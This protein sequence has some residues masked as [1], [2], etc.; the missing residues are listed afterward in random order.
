M[1]D[2][3]HLV[4]PSNT[5]DATS[6]QNTT[7]HYVTKLGKDIDLTAGEY[8]CALLELQYPNTYSN[9]LE[10]V[11][12]RY[13]YGKSQYVPLTVGDGYVF[14]I[15]NYQ[16]MEEVISTFQETVVD[17]NVVIKIDSLSGQSMIRVLANDNW[18]SITVEIHGQLL[19]MLGYDDSKKSFMS[20]DNHKKYY[21][22]DQINKDGYVLS[23]RKAKAF[24]NTIISH[25]IVNMETIEKGIKTVQEEKFMLR[26]GFYKSAE[27]LTQ[28]LMSLIGK[29]NVFFRIDNVTKCS[30][31]KVKNAV[32]D[33]HTTT[34]TL[35]SHLYRMLGYHGSEPFKSFHTIDDHIRHYP[36]DT[37]NEDG[38]IISPFPIKLH[39]ATQTM[40]I[41][42]DCI[43]YQIVSHSYT[44]LLRH[45]PLKVTDQSIISHEFKH[46]RYLKVNKD[47]LQNIEIQLNNDIGGEIE[48]T[49]GVV[50]LTIGFRRIR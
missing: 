25:I 47:V 35:G 17:L 28:T 20:P 42:T 18:R 14:P 10:D 19:R 41:Y 40:Y 32:E 1:L 48:F 13:S 21:P 12:I 30:M 24:K 11:E 38:W 44:P 26:K 39:D 6:H 49:S 34:L 37:I 8:E 2:S 45:I 33:Q 27:M 29:E 43:E 16:S 5:P 22:D 31:I 3:F 7:S 50:I 4:L 9:V 15:A 23:P 46:P 36:N